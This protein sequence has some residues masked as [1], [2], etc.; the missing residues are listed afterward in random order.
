MSRIPKDILERLGYFHREVEGLFRKLFEEQLGPGALGEEG[1]YPPVDVV[2]TEGEILIRADLPGTDKTEIELY[3]A[4][5]FLVIRGVKKATQEKW[6]YLRIERSFGSFQRLVVLP[7]P[8]DPSRVRA[9]YDQGVLE[10]RVPKVVDRRRIHQ[11][12]PIE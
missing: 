9:R 8:G 4:P 10:V 6:A 3:G 2:E 12:I 7:V 5:N 1:G 11:Q